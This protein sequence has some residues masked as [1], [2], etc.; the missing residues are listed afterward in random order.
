MLSHQRCQKLIEKTFV[1]D[2]HAKCLEL[3]MGNK[4]TTSV[5]S[6]LCLDVLLTVFHRGRTLITIERTWVASEN[7]LA[8]RGVACENQPFH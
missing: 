2:L 1:V 5:C 7:P 6:T 3:N 8:I 4:P